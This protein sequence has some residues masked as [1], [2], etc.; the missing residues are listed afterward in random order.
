[1]L[2]CTALA[3]AHGLINREHVKIVREAM[4]RIPPA[5][6]V[7]TRTRSKPNLA[8]TAIGVGPKELKDNADRTLFLLD[9]DDPNP[10][11]PNA[12]DVA[13]CGP[14]RRAPTR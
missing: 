5:V 6:D 1:M 8:R 9:Q 3:Q 7:L 2:P 4:E 10:T 14:G 12:R 11:T 13:A